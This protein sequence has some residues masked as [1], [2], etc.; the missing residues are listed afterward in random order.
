MFKQVSC[1]LLKLPVQQYRATCFVISR[2][3]S[4]KTIILTVNILIDQRGYEY[5]VYGM[6]M[7]LY[8]I[9]RVPE[10]RFQKIDFVLYV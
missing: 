6:T 5:L 9:I 8:V 2:E 10:M 3:L 7:S 4:L 1:R